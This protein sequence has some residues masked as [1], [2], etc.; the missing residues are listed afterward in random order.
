MLPLNSEL[1]KQ[2]G[3][4]QKSLSEKTGLDKTFI[5]RI[6]NGTVDMQLSTFL[7][8]LEGLGKRMKLV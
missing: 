7:R 6:E 2:M 4:T 3:L 1:R 5:S 8:I